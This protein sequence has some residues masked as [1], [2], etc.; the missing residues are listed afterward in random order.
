MSGAIED[1]EFLQVEVADLERRLEN[2]RLRLTLATAAEQSSR[3][4]TTGP[5]EHP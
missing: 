4:P 3:D 1:Q 5:L 2:A